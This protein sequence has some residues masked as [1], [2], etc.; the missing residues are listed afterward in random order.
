MGMRR[1]G[2]GSM[3]VV[4]GLLGMLLQLDGVSEAAVLRVEIDTRKPVLGGKVFGRY[5]AYELIKGRIF[6][7]FDPANAMNARIVDLNLAPRNADGLVEAWADLTVLQ[8]VDQERA[9]RVGLVEVCNRGRTFSPWYFN[10]AAGQTLDPNRAED[11]GDGLLMR[12]G[13]TVIWVGWQFDVPLREGLLRLHVPRVTNVLGAPIFGIVRSDWTVD[14]EITSLKLSHRDHIA[15]PVADPAHPDNVLTVRDGREA[16]RRTV[17]RREW[18]FAREERGK[19]IED[20]TSIYKASGFQPGKIYELVYRAKDPAVVGLGLA[21]IRD[22]ISYA[23]YEEN[24]VFPVRFGT[25]VGVSQTGRFLRHFIYQGFNTDESGRMAYDGLMTI[26]A[27]G[28]RGSFN[29]RFAQPSRD[30]HRYSAFFYPT[31]IFPFTSAVQRDPLQ[32]RSDGLLAHLHDAAHAPKVFQIN[33]GYEYWGRAAGLIHT[34]VDGSEDVPAMDDERIYHLASGQHFVVSF[35]PHSPL[36][37]T[38][39]RAFRGNPLEFNV[40]M[41]ALLVRLVEWVESGRQPPA[42]RHPRIGDGTLVPITKVRFPQIPDIT[43]PQV[44]HTAYRADYGP[45]WSQGI[46]D[47]QPPALGKPFPAL[48]PQVDSLGNEIGGVRN[49]EVRVPL[50]TYTP[51]SLRSGYPGGADEL[52]DFYGNFIPLPRTDAEKSRT[53][54]PRPSIASMYG[55]KDDY[56]SRVRDEAGSLVRE[57]FLLPEDQDYVLA[58]ASAYWDWLHAKG[59]E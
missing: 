12:L 31:D 54:D 57:G 8:P 55:S 4:F 22:V 42:S 40:N 41:R 29:H 33:A 13:L 15:Y 27:G 45:R 39:K 34:T 24:S 52:I 30:A 18:R 1:V 53:R 59:L 32:W 3:W 16:Q 47:Y 17:P 43:F 49:V 2:R 35:P 23:K 21:A 50:A 11:F 58:R 6:F 46:V 26:V 28:G 37:S 25:A 48:V 9:R 7:G 14:E 51:W 10:R 20:P 56:M 38:G 44:V 5:G 19:V 36:P